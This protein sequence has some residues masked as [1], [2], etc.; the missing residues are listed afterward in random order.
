M[1]L[2]RYFKIKIYDPLGHL[3]VD[4]QGNDIVIGETPGYGISEGSLSLEELLCDGELK[5]GDYNA[6]KFEVE[7]FGLTYDVTGYGIEIYND[8]TPTWPVFTGTI[9]SSKTNNKNGYRD[10]VAYDPMYFKRNADVTDTWNTFWDRRATASVRDVRNAICTAVGLTPPVTNLPNDTAVMVNIDPLYPSQSN[11]SPW[12]M[13]KI[14]IHNGAWCRNTGSSDVPVYDYLQY[15]GNVVSAT[16]PI[17]AAPMFETAI[18]GTLLKM[19]CEIQC[20][21]PNIARNGSL[22]FIQLGANNP[23]VHNISDNVDTNEANFKDYVTNE[24]TGF[25][26]YATSDEVSQWEPALNNNNPYPIAGNVFLLNL[27]T[28]T[29]NMLAVVADGYPT[30]EG[31]SYNTALNVIYPYLRRII[32]RP[33]ELPVIVS[34]PDIHLGD[35]LST[36]FG[37]TTYYHFVFSQSFSGS[38]LINQTIESPAHGQ[39]L[40]SQP[41]TENDLMVLNGKYYKV[42]RTVDGVV[43]EFGDN[44]R[45]TKIERTIDGITVTGPDGHTTMVSGA[46]VDTDTLRVNKIVPQGRTIQ[47]SPYYAEMSY[48]S[49]DVV[50]GTD[51]TA[52]DSK[53][54]FGSVESNN[55]AVPQILLTILGEDVPNGLI[56]RYHDEN[57]DGLWI[58]SAGG[59]TDGVGI[60]IDFTKNEQGK[61]IGNLWKYKNGDRYSIADNNTVIARFG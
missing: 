59:V 2:Q 6:N 33:A 47:D 42:T 20:C 58:G 12:E 34:D 40:N 29:I 13:D 55:H 44:G 60:F 25:A 57:Y 17:L 10:I 46:F 61:Y 51:Q 52:V 9:E 31:V 24:P 1:N 28:K 38:L 27:S 48:N 22:E 50:L 14:F 39:Q 49:M 21:C 32:Y 35:K 43:E 36:N 4:E 56:R 3:I 18:F 53:I 19:L 37:G 26:I 5:L 11:P 41:S 7:I 45:V 30:Y 16:T 15:N 8:E 23:V 54:S